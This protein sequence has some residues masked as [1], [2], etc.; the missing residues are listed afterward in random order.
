M[1]TWRNAFDVPVGYSDHTLGTAVPL[2]AVALGACMIEKHFTLDKSLDGWDHAIS[3]DPAELQALSEGSRAVFAALG[4]TARRIG[5]SEIEK[6][7]TFR[8]RMVA[9]RALTRG[10]RLNA[11]DVEFKRPGT[12][13]QPDELAYVVGR[14]VARDIAPEEELEWSDLA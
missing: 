2:A 5:P 4:G 7:K 12:G 11:A 6:R 10:E 13:I 14:P 3:A 9:K 1:D 8:R